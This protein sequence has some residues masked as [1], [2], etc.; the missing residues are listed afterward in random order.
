MAVFS[1]NSPDRLVKQAEN[2]VVLAKDVAKEIKEKGHAESKEV[3]VYEGV[4]GIKRATVDMLNAPE[5]ETFYLLG[6]SQYSTGYPHGSSEFDWTAFHARR[7]KKNIK[8]RGLYDT[9]VDPLQIKLRN[10]MPLAE[11]K[12][13]PFKLE[14]P[15]WFDICNDSVAIMVPGGLVFNIRNK[16]TA[17]ALKKYFDFL[18]NLDSS[19]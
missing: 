2:S 13:L 3:V 4:E 10:E 15:V 12:Y 7:A 11:A 16:P 6:A 8:F 1:A 18:W 14:M 5:G 17:D 9:S 19:N